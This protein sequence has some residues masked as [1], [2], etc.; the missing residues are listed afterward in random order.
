MCELFGNILLSYWMKSILD[1]CKNLVVVEF[2]YILSS[3]DNGDNHD[4]F[5][6]DWSDNSLIHV[7]HTH[8][9]LFILL[10]SFIFFCMHFF[11]DVSPINNFPS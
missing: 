9:I 8:I 5:R 1:L 7:L 3:F 10:I 11:R 4:L 2:I 6:S